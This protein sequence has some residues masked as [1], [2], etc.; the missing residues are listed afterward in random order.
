MKILITGGCGFIGS[1]IAV[2]LLENNHDI[3]ILDNLINCKKS[4]L[5]KIKQITNKNFSFHKVDIKNAEELEKIFQENNIELVIHLA[6]LKSVSQSKLDPM[7]YFDNNVN[8]SI[9]LINIMN[10]YNVKKIIFSSSATVYKDSKIMPLKESNPVE[11]SSPYGHSKLMTEKILNELS[12]S[13]NSW[14]VTV[15]RYFNPVGAHKSGIIGEDPNSGSDNLVPHILKAAINNEKKLHIFGDDYETKD[16]TGIRDYIHINDLVN[17]HICAVNKMVQTSTDKN[18][19]VI[20]LGSGMGFSVKEIISEFEKVIGKK[21][22]VVID[23][24]RVGDVAVSFTDN[25][26]A[27][28]YLEWDIKE[29]LKSICED[30]WNWKKKNNES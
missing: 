2:K 7:S 19:V 17:G 28:K 14:Q 25:S 26:F 29:S 22:N 8:G 11:P 24:R 30:A 20:N 15:L 6:G 12:L 4:T 21:I 9:K 3:I 23:K 1:H 5:D 18:Y 13:D 27:K 10:K 16:G